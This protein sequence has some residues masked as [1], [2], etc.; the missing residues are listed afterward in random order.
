MKK[1]IKIIGIILG[2]IVLLLIIGATYINVK[3]IPKYENKAPELTVRVDSAGIAEGARMAAMMCANCHRSKDGKLGGGPMKD[4]GD[5]GKWYAPNI[6]HHP[7]FGKI[8]QY[9]DGE[10]AYLLRTGI[11]KDGGYSPPWM[12][13]F[14]HLSDEDLHN[15]IGF[16]RSDHP[17]VKPSD[18]NPPPNEPS[19]LAKLLCNTAF[20]PLPYPDKPIPSPDPNDKVAF[21]KYIS[22]A[23]FECFTCHSADFA[24]VDLM[25][26][27]NSAGYFGG[28]NLLKDEKG[29]PIPSSNLTMDKETGLGNWTEEE[30]IRT[31]KTGIRPN[32]PATRSP[33]IPFAQMTDEEVSAIWAYL[34]TLPVI[35]NPNDVVAEVKPQ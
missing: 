32:G 8:D 11:K 2:A 14:P 20:Q 22:T 17:L 10:L 30:F 13:K 25:Q 31:V 4:T 16:L 19:F 28:G 29:N 7:E 23:K 33:M 18:N 35:N 5:L 3:G 15:L 26:P 12:A 6:T 34:N 21:G 27:E 9:T 1:A 24:K